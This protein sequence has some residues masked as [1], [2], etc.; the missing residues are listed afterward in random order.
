MN[1]EDLKNIESKLNEFFINDKKIDVIENSLMKLNEKKEYLKNQIK[2]LKIN[3][4]I[5]IKSS[6]ISGIPVAINNTTS[7]FEKDIIKQIEKSESLL[8]SID[9][10][11]LKLENELLILQMRNEK[12][13][14]IMKILS[15][16]IKKL[17][18]YKYK[19]NL[20][21]I[22]ISNKLNISIPNYHRK[23]RKALDTIYN[24]LM[25]YENL[26]V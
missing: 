12:F 19:E 2:D 23:K 6:S 22:E 18:I 13:Y 9:I 4:D 11:I 26:E 20:S 10:E 3:F 16:N 5:S 15:S 7:Y 1:F 24:M 8:N 21:E 14:G 25:F 17:L